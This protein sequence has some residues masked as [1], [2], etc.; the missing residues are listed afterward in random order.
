MR[1]QV[2]GFVDDVGKSA[3]ANCGILN[4]AHEIFLRW[5]ATHGATFAP[6]KYEMVHLTRSPRRFNMTATL[7]LGTIATE[8]KAVSGSWDFTLMES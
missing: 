2:G 4:Q 5:A 3:K 7:D 1:L 6:G 8:P